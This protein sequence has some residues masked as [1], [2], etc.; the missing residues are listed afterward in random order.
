MHTYC[1][2][3]LFS[4]EEAV[5]RASDLGLAAIGICDH[6]TIAG[7]EDAIAAGEKYGVEIIP[8]VELSSQFKGRDIHILGYYFDFNNRPLSDYMKL[9]REERHKRA[10][11]MVVNLNMDGV[12]INM[13]DVVE[14]SQGKSIGRPHIAEVLMEKG[15]VETFQEAFHRFIGYGASSYVEKYKIE[16]GGAIRLI[17]EARGLSV[18]AHPGPIVT[19][20]MIVDLIKNGL[21]GIEVIHPNLDERRTSHLIGIARQYDLLISGG[22]DCHGGRSGDICMGKYTVPYNVLQDMKDRK[23]RMDAA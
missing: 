22:S 12:Q 18:L 5:Q 7:L 8:G 14:K 3:G 17:S 4:P 16:P 19:D 2:D 10:A 6:D 13:D 23:S 1:S 20:E 15:Y 11:K 9:F 21:D